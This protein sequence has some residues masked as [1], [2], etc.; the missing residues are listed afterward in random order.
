MVGA[1]LL[2]GCGAQKVPH[3]NELNDNK[4]R[5]Y[6]K[7]L[8]S[9]KDNF[10]QTKKLAEAGDMEAQNTLG[11]MYEVGANVPQDYKEA[12]RWY[13]KA[14][15]QGLQEA[16]FRIAIHYFM[17]NGVVEDYVTSFVV[18]VNNHLNSTL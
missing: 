11:L 1:L 6:L 18:L 12:C 9:E 14:A 7:N 17:G 15:E 8:L 10:D 4:I 3:A 13:L 5:L 16:Q 2:I